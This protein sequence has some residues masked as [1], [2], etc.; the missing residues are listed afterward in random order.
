MG[1]FTDGD[2]TS[3]AFSGSAN[4]THGGLIENYEAIDVFWSWEDPRDVLPK[5]FAV[6]I[7]F[8][9]GMHRDWR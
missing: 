6:L 2:G 9:Q 5:R 3:V 8:G 7:K 1:I 4:E